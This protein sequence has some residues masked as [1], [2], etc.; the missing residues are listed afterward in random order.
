MGRIGGW[1]GTAGTVPGA[2]VLPA[3]DVPTLELDPGDA[4]RVIGWLR[5]GGPGRCGEGRRW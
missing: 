1:I 5:A 4:A 2:A 3:G